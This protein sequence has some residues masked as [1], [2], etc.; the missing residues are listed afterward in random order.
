MGLE[1]S[2][3]YA[4]ASIATTAIGTGV[5][6]YSQNQ[7]QKTTDRI[8]AHNNQLAENEARNRELESQE[9]IRRER[10]R[11]RAQMARVR[12]Q[13][14][15]GGTLTTTG[16]PLAILGE[17]ASR[18]ETGIADAYRRSNMDAASLRAR[19][20]MGLWE[21]DQAA[22][23]TNLAMAGTAIKGLSSAASAY[24]GAAYQGSVPDF[25]LYT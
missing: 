17:T 2:A 16:T 11:K 13:L 4:I 20:Q 3:I 6:I 12:N 23:G 1:V 24:S 19:G 15:A 25:G 10:R 5:S 7:Q 21:A 8:A 22:A 9:A 14:A 18:I